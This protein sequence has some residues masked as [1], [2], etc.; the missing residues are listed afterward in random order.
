MVS[1]WAAAP[2]RIVTDAKTDTVTG[3]AGEVA[4]RL[5]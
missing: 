2:A 1:A 3:D 5:W 4:D